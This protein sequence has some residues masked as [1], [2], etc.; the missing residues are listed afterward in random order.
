MKILSVMILALS[1]L[2]VSSSGFAVTFK[3]KH[4]TTEVQRKTANESIETEV[5]LISQIKNCVSKV[6]S[7]EDLDACA[8]EYV[9]VARTKDQKKSL[10]LWFSLPL[11]MPTPEKCKPEDLEFVSDKIIK[12]SKTALCSSYNIHGLERKTIFLISEE[13]GKLK[14]INLKE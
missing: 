8:K 12:G 1:I 9:S 3:A 2:G 5:A 10:L 4:R 14:L 13:N 11:E 7:E 6:K